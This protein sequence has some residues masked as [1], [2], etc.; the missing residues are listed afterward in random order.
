MATVEQLS[1]EVQS[2]KLDTATQEQK[3]ITHEQR[4]NSAEADI[5]QLQENNKAIYEINTNV[6]ILAEGINSVKSD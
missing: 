3:I 2:L 5:K 6:R 4:L 1:Q